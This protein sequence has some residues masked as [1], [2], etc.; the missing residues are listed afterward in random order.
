MDEGRGGV[1]VVL[2]RQHVRGQRD[3]GEEGRKSAS[4]SIEMPEYIRIKQSFIIF[5]SF[6]FPAFQLNPRMKT[7]LFKFKSLFF[8]HKFFTPKKRNFISRECC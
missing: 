8:I 2:L 5:F 4:D 1:E 3:V 6:S 7:Q